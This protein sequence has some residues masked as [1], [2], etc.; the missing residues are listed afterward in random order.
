VAI[1]SLLEIELPEDAIKEYFAHRRAHGGWF[2]DIL[3]RPDLES[4][5]HAL[6]VAKNLDFPLTAPLSTMRYLDHYLSRDK[7]EHDP[8]GALV[9]LRAA[10]NLDQ[11]GSSD[12]EDLVRQIAQSK[13]VLD[14]QPRPTDPKLR[15]WML[16]GQETGATVDSR[17][18]TTLDAA[19]N[20]ATPVEANVVTVELLGALGLLCGTTA[21]ADQIAALASELTHESGGYRPDRLAATPS[22]GATNTVLRVLA[23]QGLAGLVDT[24]STRA[25][26]RSR[27][28]EHGYVDSHPDEAL[29]KMQSQSGSNTLATTAA[30]L[31]IE[32]VLDEIEQSGWAVSK[33]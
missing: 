20:A 26:V 11:H 22:L 28:G 2:N 9:A 21:Y 7:V 15:A 8:A 4:T 33:N 19:F 25:F 12:R 30:G 17:T 14:G 13:L 32:R 10:K 24:A 23:D 27:L 1:A 5:A 3:M 18:C 29:A 6:I 16:L 31:E